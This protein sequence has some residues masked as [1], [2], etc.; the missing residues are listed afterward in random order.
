MEAPA[1]ARRVAG[2]L[3]DYR[4]PEDGGLEQVTVPH[5]RHLESAGFVVVQPSEWAPVTQGQ[6][7]GGGGG[8]GNLLN[9]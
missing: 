1:A 3:G 6:S 7:S 8:L 9:G 2:V 4:Q 5:G